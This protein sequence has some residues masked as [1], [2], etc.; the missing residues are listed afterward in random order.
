ME[1][2]ERPR[3]WTDDA[4]NPEDL[5]LGF[6][7]EHVRLA[8]A[9]VVDALLSQVVASGASRATALHARQRTVATA[10]SYFWRFYQRG[11]FATDEPVLVAVACLSL[12]GKT[13]ENPVHDHTKFVALARAVAAETYSDASREALFA[14]APDA[15]LP[16]E[17]RV[18]DALKFDL[19][20]YDPHAALQEALRGGRRSPAKERARRREGA[21][22]DATEAPSETGRIKKRKRD[23][24]DDDDDDDDTLFRVAWGVLNDSLVTPT[25]VSV[26]ERA[27][28]VAAV[29]VACELLDVEPPETAFPDGENAS[30]AGAAADVPEG[31][32]ALAA[33]EMVR[34]RAAFA[35]NADSKGRGAPAEAPKGAPA[36]W[37]ARPLMLAARR[38]QAAQ[39]IEEARRAG[40]HSTSR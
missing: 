25:C 18:L 38:A 33:R 8:K 14:C 2:P 13:L 12:A 3:G 37:R 4:S 34:H 22:T 30:L 16:C 7:P 11:S 36:G 10:V 35:E 39:I 21:E 29:A 6:S 23:D 5:R 24:D 19:T 27:A 40:R 17:L 9:V 1:R 15:L 20:P 32:V 31:H 28:A 26:S